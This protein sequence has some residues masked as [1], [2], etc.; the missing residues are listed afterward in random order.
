[1]GYFLYPKKKKRNK[2]SASLGKCTSLK[3]RKWDE[4][5]ILAWRLRSLHGRKGRVR[6]NFTGLW[7]SSSDE[8][9]ESGIRVKADP[10]IL[11]NLILG[12]SFDLVSLSFHSK[13]SYK[14]VP[15]CIPSSF[16]R[17]NRRRGF[18]SLNSNF[19]QEKNVMRNGFWTVWR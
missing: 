13:E 3:E 8:M 2:T 5:K 14:F 10:D 12:P 15:T 4:N 16:W 11:L 1:M 19:S 6:K 7:N 9:T 18:K 17:Q